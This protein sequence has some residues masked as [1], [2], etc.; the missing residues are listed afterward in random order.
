MSDYNLGG[1]GQPKLI[2]DDGKTALLPLPNG[3][4]RDGVEI[5]EFNPETVNEFRSEG[6]KQIEVGKKFLF[7]ANLK[8]VT[9]SK[10]VLLDLFKAAAQ[11]SF[12][13]QIHDDDNTVKYRCKVK[14]KVDFQLIKGIRN[15]PGGYTIKVDL[16]GTEFVDAPFMGAQGLTDGF[17][18][19]YGV[20]AQN[21][22]P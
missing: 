6:N 21:Q 9:A 11:G 18:T 8:W 3:A 2:F 22:S 19:D 7:G 10:K 17:G 20:N 1:T 12:V 16:V 4:S 5:Y 13:Y 14:G 15:H